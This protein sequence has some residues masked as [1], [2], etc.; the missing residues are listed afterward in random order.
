M[1][2]ELF[3][4]LEPMFEKDGLLAKLYPLYE[5]AF[6]LF[7]SSGKVTTGNTHVRDYIDLKRIMIIVYFAVFPTMI[8]GW[9]NVGAQTVA[10]IAC[11]I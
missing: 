7:F 4:K 9:Y 11:F 3:K 5:G 1:L 10:A 6:T 8:W 2:L